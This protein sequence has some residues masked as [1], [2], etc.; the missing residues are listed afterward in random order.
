M[1]TIKT[2]RQMSANAR[3]I[4]ASGETL[5]LVPTMGFLHEGHLALVDSACKA[6]DK[7]VVSIFVNRAQF[8][9]REDL[10]SYP[11]NTRRD[12]RLLRQRGVDLVFMPG[13]KE[14]YPPGYE[15]YV[16][17][18][19]LSLTLEGKFRPGH[20]R[21]VT[22]VVAKLFN[23]CWPDVAVFGQKDFQQAVVLKKMAADMGYPI[24]IIVAPTVREPDGLALSSRNSYFTESQRGE[25]ACLY[26]GL[27]AARRA[28]RAGEKN[29]ANLK[30][31]IRREARRSCNTVKFDYIAITDCESLRPMTRA[32]KG[33]VIL[34]AARVHGVRLIDNIRL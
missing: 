3:R 26:R 2:A 34:L 25:A 11:R 13:A 14:I 12:L 24:K 10:R 16:D 7:V 8:G 5:A 33:A 15:T 4:I 23:I 31:L 17:V 6:A 29:S 32:R 30:N 22:T 18:E 28:F 20:F 21:G 27:T 19:K 9:P 1:R